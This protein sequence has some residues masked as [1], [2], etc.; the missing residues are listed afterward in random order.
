MSHSHRIA[1]ALLVASA[2]LAAQELPPDSLVVSLDGRVTVLHRTDLASLPP[3]HVTLP[4]G[5]GQTHD[6]TGIPLRAALERAG[7]DTAH[8]SGP[9][10]AGTMLLV[11]RD[12]YR[13]A[14][15]LADLDSAITGRALLL[16]YAIDGQPLDERHGPWQLLVPGDLHGRRSVR[17]VT[18]VVIRQPE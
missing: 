15:G 2:P 9:A 16:A 17:Q 4:T 1:L 3:T 12:G 5:D 11:A 8:I 18:E 10:L 14:F 7:L 13:V 6:Y